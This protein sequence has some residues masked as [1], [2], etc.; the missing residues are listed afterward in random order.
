MTR[1]NSN[2]RAPLSLLPL[3]ADTRG[4]GS[5]VPHFGTL[6]AYADPSAHGRGFTS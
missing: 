3:R 4:A 5:L 6:A 1:T 2:T